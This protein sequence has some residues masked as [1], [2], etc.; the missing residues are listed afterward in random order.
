M[1]AGFR[2]AKAGDDG[3]ELLGVDDGGKLGPVGL[4]NFLLHPGAMESAEGEGIDGES[5]SPLLSHF[6][7]QP[8][9]GL[10]ILQIGQFSEVIYGVCIGA[11]THTEAFMGGSSSCREET[12]T[13]QGALA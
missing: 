11:A 8:I 4:V 5:I 12:T 2:R 9:E 7:F 6:V 3:E 10:R 1:T 13:S